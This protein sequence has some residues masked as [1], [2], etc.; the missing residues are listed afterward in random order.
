MTE[1]DKNFINL[2]IEAV[3]ENIDEVIAELKNA[4]IYP[5]ESEQ[6]IMLMVKKQ[7]AELKI[8]K[9]KQLKERVAEIIKLNAKQSDTKVTEERFAIA[10]RKLGSIDHNDIQNIKKDAELLEDIGKLLD[11]VKSDA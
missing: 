6:K 8:E 9:G 7:K 3:D 10:A 11:K 1:R 5:E 2:Y 4:G